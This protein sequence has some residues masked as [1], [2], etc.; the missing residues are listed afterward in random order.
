MVVICK[1]K[2][3]AKTLLELMTLST[4][5][6]MIAKDEEF[7]KRISEMS[8]KGREKL[9]DF[10]EE[11]NGEDEKSLSDKL[12]LKASQ[13]KEELEQKIGEMVVKLY[14]KMNIAHTE[15]IKELRTQIES[16]KKEIALAEARI[17]SLET[18]K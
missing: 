12:L 4:N 9:E 15:Q 16:L 14:D 13:A 7:M 6:Y 11:M 2:M 17:V 3:R 8:T 10:L 1:K 5:L 18:N